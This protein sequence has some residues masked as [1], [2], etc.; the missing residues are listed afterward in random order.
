MHK[1]GGRRNFGWGKQIEWAGKQALRAAFGGGHYGTVASH[2]ARWR[3]FCEWT[4]DRGI[5]DV[6]QISRVELAQ[7]ADHLS[8]QTESGV[9]LGYAK[10]Q[11]TSVNVVMESLRGDRVLWVKPSDFLGNRSTVRVA[12]PSGLDRVLVK[13]ATDK[14]IS[15]GKGRVA[16]IALLCREL[17]LRRR[18]ASLLDLRLAKHQAVQLGR[19]NVTAGTKGGRGRSVDRW[20]PASEYAKNAIQLATK[21]A[22]AGSKLIP[23]DSSLAQWLTKVSKEWSNVA[24][25]LGLESL[26]DLRAAYA[27]D[28]YMQLT[29]TQAPAVAGERVA[30]KAVDQA[31]RSVLSREL[32]HNRVDVLTAYVGS[33]R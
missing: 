31:A 14:L 28:R 23:T 7:F 6:R 27:C 30:E 2:S 3:K 29:D 9:S 22:D 20:V 11:L 24:V 12:A 17:G 25:P 10:N 8:R 21:A 4:R 15:G 19:L 1:V 33:S 26:R 32:G 16:A 18:E 13:S 5:R